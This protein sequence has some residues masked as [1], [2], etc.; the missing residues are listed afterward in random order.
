MP[1]PSECPPSDH[2]SFPHLSFPERRTY[3]MAPHLKYELRKPDIRVHA[4]SLRC[5]GMCPDGRYLAMGADD[6][7]LFVSTANDGVLRAMILTHAPVVSIS[8]IANIVPSLTFACANGVIA[9]LVI[10]SEIIQATY[11]RAPSH[12]I[13]HIALT[14]SGSQM[15]SGSGN[16]VRVWR[17]ISDGPWSHYRS[18]NLR[19]PSIHS[20]PICASTLHW[21]SPGD[22]TEHLIVSYKHHAICIWDVD[23]ASVIRTIG[24]PELLGPTVLSHDSKFL[25]VA[26]RYIYQVY[27][28]ESGMVTRTFKHKLG[29]SV[30]E[31][32]VAF[33]HGGTAFLG[34][35]DA[36]ALRMWDLVKQT[37]MQTLQC[38]A[39]VPSGLLTY[40]NLQRGDSEFYIA[41]A[42]QSK[43]AI[44]KTITLAMARVG[45]AQLFLALNSEPLTACGVRVV[46]SR[47]GLPAAFQYRSPFPRTRQTESASG[48]PPGTPVTK[49]NH[50][51]LRKK[52]L[53]TIS[54]VARGLLKSSGFQE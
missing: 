6:G 26:R 31:L 46:S 45:C 9:D 5:I 8:W 53:E 54:K 30:H 11:F 2:F 40:S 19:Q 1:P 41:A 39:H 3:P 52:W 20:R 10:S 38:A 21:Y 32:R 51:I 12:Q 16:D 47:A 37:K 35:Y 23:T 29:S 22:G 24:P 42:C 44:F 25:A 7:R 43:V 4:E 48:I 50:A 49:P 17:K 33:A 18:L 34:V 27:D 36:G 15:S 14:T 28:V 13:E